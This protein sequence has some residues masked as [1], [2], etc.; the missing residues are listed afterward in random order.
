[1][2]SEEPQGPEWL[3]RN[4]GS[5]GGNVSGGLPGVVLAQVSTPGL[6]S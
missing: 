1:M 6:P 5:G 3:S 2:Q 4:I